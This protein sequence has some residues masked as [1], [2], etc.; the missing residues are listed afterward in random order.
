MQTDKKLDKYFYITGWIVIALITVLVMIVK[1]N[2][3]G[4]L[5]KMPPCAFNKVTGLYCPGCGGTRATI[6]LFRGQIIRSFRFHPF[7]LYGFVVGGWF[8]I[9]QTIQ[10]ISKDRIK[11]RM[12]FRPVYLWIALAIVLIN[13]LVKN[14]FILIGGIDL[15]D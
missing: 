10:R 3:I 1:I 9:S 6:A 12:H 14:A 2:G 7:V 11:I 4:I 13:W 5:H 15:L 8:M